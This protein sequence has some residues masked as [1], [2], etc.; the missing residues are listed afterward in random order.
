MMISDEKL[1]F[2]GVV[3]EGLNIRQLL[4]ITFEQF[5]TDPDRYFN[6]AMAM[7]EGDGMVIHEGMMTTV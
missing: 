7:R 2:Y 5:L 4:Q 6:N 1:D 3:F